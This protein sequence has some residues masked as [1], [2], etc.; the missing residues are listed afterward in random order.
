MVYTSTNK[1]Y[2]KKKNKD[3]EHQ[4]PVIWSIW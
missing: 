3:E 2:E 1:A 4:I